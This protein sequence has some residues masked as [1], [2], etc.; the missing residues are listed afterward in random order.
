VQRGSRGPAA[1]REASYGRAGAPRRPAVGARERGSPAADTRWAQRV[2]SGEGIVR[3][4]GVH[5]EPQVRLVP[6]CV[7]WQIEAE[8]LR[9]E[10]HQAEAVL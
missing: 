7:A 5:V 8:R 9:R 1:R 2:G 3:L 4:R 6:G 10:E